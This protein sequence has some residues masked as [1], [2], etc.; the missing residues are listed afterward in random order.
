MR[1]ILLGIE[2]VKLG[3]VGRRMH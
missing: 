3:E 2:G 1:L